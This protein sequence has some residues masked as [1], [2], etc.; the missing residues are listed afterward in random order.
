M[1][2]STMFHRIDSRLR[3]ITGK[4]ESF[5]SVSVIAVG[6]L[7]QLPP[8]MDSPIYKFGSNEFSGLFNRNPLWDEFEFFEHTEVMR[9]KEDLKFVNVLNNIATGNIS[10]ED[11]NFINTRLVNPST[12]PASAM[13]LF[14]TN[15]L[16]DQYN[17]RKTSE[18]PGEEY[19]SVAIDTVAGEPTENTKTKILNAIRKKKN[20]RR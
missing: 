2:G 20:Y 5:G 16:V 11:I 7:H 10:I 4:N 1:V 19:K 13:Q 8:V 18:H 15:I 6:A 9:Q 17:I 14:P 3:Q 12:V